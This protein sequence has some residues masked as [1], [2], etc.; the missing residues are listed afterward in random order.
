MQ[1]VPRFAE[2]QAPPAWRTVD[3]ISDLHLQASQPRTFDAWRDY[4]SACS[5]DALFILGDL[6]ELWIGDDVLHEPGFA[7]D[8]ASVIHATARRLQF[9]EAWHCL[10]A[11]RCGDQPTTTALSIPTSSCGT[12]WWKPFVHVFTALMRSTTSWTPMNLTNNA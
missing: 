1:A 4:M 7:A 5:A 11:A 2:L 9:R 3:F 10:H 8:C 12:S 6:F